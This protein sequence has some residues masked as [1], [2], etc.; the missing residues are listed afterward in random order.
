[1]TIAQGFNKALGQVPSAPK[2]R[3]GRQKC[4]LAGRPASPR[5]LHLPSR[6][7]LVKLLLRQGP[8]P[9]EPFP[10]IPSFES[11]VIG[12]RQRIAGSCVSSGR[13]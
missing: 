11:R 1:M 6:E 8:A 2:S 9:G 7:P 4:P 13:L 5:A 12:V 3:Q 10:V